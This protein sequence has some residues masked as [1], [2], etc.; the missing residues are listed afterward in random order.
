MQHWGCLGARAWNVGVQNDA[1]N[2]LSV[3]HRLERA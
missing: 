2:L 1:G 3:S